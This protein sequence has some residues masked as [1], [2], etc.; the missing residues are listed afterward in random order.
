[1]AF[2]GHHS[3]L[4]VYVEALKRIDT[5]RKKCFLDP[6]GMSAVILAVSPHNDMP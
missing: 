4:F 5:L 1:M 3:Q 6:S 2:D